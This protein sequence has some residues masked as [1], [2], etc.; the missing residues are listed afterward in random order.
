M[1]Q[2]FRLVENYLMQRVMS[3][4]SPL[5]HVNKT[6]IVLL[7]VGGIL[8]AISLGFV[9]LGVYQWLQ[10]GFNSYEAHMIFGAVLLIVALLSFLVIGFIQ[11]Q[12]KKKALAFKNQIRDE[13]LLN[14]KLAEA[15]IKDLQILETYP[16][17]CVAFSTL[18]GFI[19]AEKAL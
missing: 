10:K 16:K 15:E 7:L 8:G 6:V 3:E 18:A 14:L 11:S 2:V 17:T 12:K 5:S 9:L 13:V 19:L 1:E 4:H